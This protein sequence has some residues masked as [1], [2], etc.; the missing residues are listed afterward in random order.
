MDFHIITMGCKINQYESQAISE[1]LQGR[2]HVHVTSSCH[3]RTI[4]INSCAVTARAVRDLK[5]LCRQTC[6]I[7]PNAEIIVTG[8][9]AQIFAKEISRLDQ[10][11]MVIPQNKKRILLN[12][13]NLS[14]TKNEDIPE[15][16]ISDYSR[17]RPVVKVQDGCTHRCTFCI[18]PL[19]RG[20]SVSR[21]PQIVLNEIIRLLNKGF[22][23]IVLGGINLRLYGRDLSPEMD[24]WDL[25]QYVHQNIN[26][27][28]HPDFRLRLSSLE[29]SE[30]NS[31]AIDTLAACQRICPHLHVS[32]Q[33]GSN[34]VLEKMNRDHYDPMHLPDFIHGLKKVW[35]VFALGADI[36]VG[37]PG[38]TEKNFQQTVS[39]VNT[40]PLTYAHVFPFS[41]R[42]G[43]Q[44]VRFTGQVKDDE[45]KLRS[46]KIHTLI[47]NKNQA[48]LQHLSTQKKLDL[49]METE[50]KGMSEYYVQCCLTRPEAINAG[51]RIR[52]RPLR[53]KGSELIAEALSQ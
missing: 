21:P 43:T 25:V 51:H 26:F 45:K 10:V 40:L 22:R 30:L 4:I 28:I 24:F 19:T 50:T 33:S 39:L 17:A 34:T 6:R 41:P 38:E 14:P 49:I 13:L 32:L 52:V 53:V 9:A 15:Y 48:F 2:G 20:D 1:S 37:F 31:K 29:P 18:V 3:A 7:N 27:S 5:K 36:M 47:M 12:G 11:S 23:E 44:A 35:P 46:K 42:P 8:C 16:R